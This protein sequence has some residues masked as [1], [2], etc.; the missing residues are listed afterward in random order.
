MGKKIK[1]VKKFLIPLGILVLI[2][3]YIGI[4]TDLLYKKATVKPI[5]VDWQVFE[6]NYTV[7]G[8]IFTPNQ[9]GRPKSISRWIDENGMALNNFLF[10][11]G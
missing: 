3:L 1:V 11:K 4:G 9:S 2:C 5:K 8:T 6:V 7:N 10:S